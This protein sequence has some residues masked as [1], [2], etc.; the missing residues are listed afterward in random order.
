ME[1]H[2]YDLPGVVVGVKHQRRYLYDMLGAH[3]VGYLGE[4]NEDQLGKPEYEDYRMGELVGQYG[5]EK[6]LEESLHG[7]RG[8]RLVEVDSSGRVLMVLEQTDPTPGDNLYLTIDV[9]LQLAAQKALGRQA[10]A[11]VA[12]DPNTGEVLAL[13]SMPTFSQNDFVQGPLP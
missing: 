5:V 11:V 9:R 1:S 12:L 2:R 3:V 7:K 6:E 10:G 13:A 8:S 4:V